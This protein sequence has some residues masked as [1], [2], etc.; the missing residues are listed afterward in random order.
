[1]VAQHGQ[2]ADVLVEM[3]AEPV[4]QNVADQSAGERQQQGFAQPEGAAAGQ[5]GDGEEHHHAGQDD[6]DDGRAFEEGDQEQDQR[7]PLRVG[8]DPG[9]EGFDVHRRMSS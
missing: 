4:G 1:M 9:V 2:A 5:H 8:A 6:A 7:Q 3:A